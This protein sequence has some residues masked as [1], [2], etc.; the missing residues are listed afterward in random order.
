[1]PLTPPVSHAGSPGEPRRPEAGRRRFLGLHIVLSEARAWPESLWSRW[2]GPARPALHRAES[3]PPSA[4]LPPPASLGMKHPTHSCW[5]VPLSHFYHLPSPHAFVKS[6][7][8][9]S[10]S[11]PAF[12]EGSC[13]LAPTPCQALLLCWCR[14]GF[15]LP[16][17]GSAA[18][19]WSDSL[20]PS[21]GFCSFH[22]S[23]PDFSDIPFSAFLRRTF[24]STL[25]PHIKW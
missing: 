7:F 4:G 18:C 11:L 10:G 24:G 9:F 5:A 21:K 8:L 12:C 22:L 25:R 19:Q 23:G 2:C 3:E 16:V 17:P 13:L 15:C 20:P 1:M 6:R 14:S